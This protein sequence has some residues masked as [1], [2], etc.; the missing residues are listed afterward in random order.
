[1]DA[2]LN[3]DFKDLLRELS[4]SGAEFLIVGAHALAVHG[5]VRATGDLDILIR[6]SDENAERVLVALR[7]F[8][9]PV[10][11][12]GI[13]PRELATPGNVYQ[14]G[15]PPRRI[16]IL[17]RISGVDFDAAW[18]SRTSTTLDGQSIAVLGRESLIENK[19]A[20]GREKDRLDVELLLK[21]EK[22]AKAMGGSPVKKPL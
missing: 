3:D 7:R 1:M 17:T 15:L 21:L 12:H 10:E 11:A 5:I 20:T 13:S 4:D 22:R 18:R 9:A 16:D 6:P 2:S 14:I 8:G 19:H